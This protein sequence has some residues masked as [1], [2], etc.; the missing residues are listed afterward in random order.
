MADYVCEVDEVQYE[1]DRQQKR[2]AEARI[3]YGK[4]SGSVQACNREDR[5]LA[6]LHQKKWRVSAGLVSDA[7]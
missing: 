6:D 4:G 2:C 7:R 3:A 5:K 1:I